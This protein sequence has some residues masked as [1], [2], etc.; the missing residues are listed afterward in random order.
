MPWPQPS[1]RFPMNSYACA[2]APSLRSARE[3][4]VHTGQAVAWYHGRVQRIL[5]EDWPQLEAFDWD[6][7]CDEGHYNLVLLCGHHH[8]AV[9]AGIWVITM[10]DGIPWMIP[11]PWITP[12]RQ[13]VRNRVAD[14]RTHAEHLGRQLR[15]AIDDPPLHRDG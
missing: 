5:T 14:A 10:R 2:P 15:L 9:H 4:L 8:T 12:D 13:P 1:P 6:A 11:P 7:A 3:C